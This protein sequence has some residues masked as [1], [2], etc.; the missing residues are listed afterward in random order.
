MM[1]SP[2]H[3]R[4]VSLVIVMMMMLLSALLVLGGARVTLLNE[5]LAGNDSDY[6]RAFEAAQMML[7]NA[8]LDIQATTANKR[9]IQVSKMEGD[10]NSDLVVL[11]SQQSGSAKCV[12]GVCSNLD[13]LVSGDPAT[14]FWNNATLL[15][16][17]TARGAT[18]RQW[19]HA[20]TLATGADKTS[21]HILAA[22]NPARAW[23]WIEILKFDTK[24]L[25]DAPDWIMACVPAASTSSDGSKLFRITALALTR[26]NTPVVVQEYF[27]PKP[28]QDGSRRC[29]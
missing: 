5:H 18:Y 21:N 29:P 11:A 27:I 16:T 20:T 6:Q 17:F 12:D 25:R 26:A 24:Q 2:A 3:Q 23:Y 22:T 13:T 14:S 10:N 28:Q 4:G 7:Q 8:E 15:P 19:T 9:T 1:H